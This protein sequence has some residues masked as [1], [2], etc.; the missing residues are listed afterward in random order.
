MAEDKVFMAAVFPEEGEPYVRSFDTIT[1]LAGF[2]KDVPPEDR[3]FLFFGKRVQITAG[4]W[5]YLIHEDQQVPAFTAPRPG[6]VDRSSS[7]G[8]KVVVSPEADEYRDLMKTLPTEPV[9]VITSDVDE[10]EEE[11]PTG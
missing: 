2:V 7:L 3:G 4:P 10:P 5:R 1:G 11:L 9:E 6:K 8:Q